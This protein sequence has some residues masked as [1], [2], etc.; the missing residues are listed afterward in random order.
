MSKPLKFSLNLSLI[1]REYTVFDRFQKAS[2]AGFKA[3]EIQFPYETSAEDLK[4]GLDAAGIQ[5]VLFNVGAG[6]L[7]QGGEGIAAV[8]EKKEQFRHAVDLAL[9]YAKVLSPRVIN[10]LPGRAYRLA[11]RKQYLDT[12]EDNLRFAA[13]VFSTLGIKTVFEAANTFDMPDFLIHS[14]RQLLDMLQ[15]VNHP[16]L[17]IQYDIYHMTRM[18]QDV[19]CFI[20]SNIDKIGHFQF[21]DAPG[22]G[23]PG[24]GGIDFKLVFDAIANTDY[25]GWLGA[26]YKPT[27]LSKDSLGWFEAF[28]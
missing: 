21:A 16:N 17:Y 2:D 23:Q 3:V 25:S 28:S 8:P 1:F 9:S 15:R 13:G 19:I 27:G 10:V 6:D 18:E 26:E 5:M 24:T 11:N 14:G 7:M 12:L 4:R 22:R 20:K